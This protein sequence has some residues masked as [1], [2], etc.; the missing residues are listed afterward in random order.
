MMKTLVVD[1]STVDRNLLTKIM[2]ELGFSCY[3][4]R[5]GEEALT[6]LSKNTEISLAMVDWSMPIV[7]GIELVRKI[8][9]EPKY[10]DIR[11]IMVTAANDIAHIDVALDA[12]IDEYVMKPYS[13]TIIAEKL[14][15]IGIKSSSE[16]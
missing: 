11:I 15:L 10:A 7:D 8:R 2:S 3:S 4:V 1:D 12:G 16:L 13:K 14:A 6:M 9:S 5:D